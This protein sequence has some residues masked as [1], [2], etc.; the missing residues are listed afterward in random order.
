MSFLASD[1]ILQFELQVSDMTELAQAEELMVLNRVRRKINRRPLEANRKPFAGTSSTSVPYVTLPTDFFR[2]APNAEYFTKDYY[3]EHPVVFFG[4][5]NT[6]IQ[7]IPYANRNQYLG[8]AGFAYIDIVNN[9]LVFLLQPTSASAVAFDY[10]ALPIDLLIGD[11]DWL[12]NLFPDALVYG[13]AVEDNILQL[14]DKARSY[15]KENEGKYEDELA[16]IA[17][18]NLSLTQL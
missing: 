3:A 14:S 6:P 4:I 16:E 17:S 8:S 2:L 13:M 10:Y 15:A 7:V 1:I 18:W 5:S 12:T 9:R 11:N